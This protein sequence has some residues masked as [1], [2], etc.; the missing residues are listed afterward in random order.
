MVEE[1]P[2]AGVHV[3]GF[4]VIDRN[5]ISVELGHPVRRAWVEGGGFALGYRL[6]QAVELGGGGLVNTGA[7]GHP[8]EAN[9]FQQT[10]GPDTVRVGGVFR[11]IKADLDVAHR[12]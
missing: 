7:V 6:H 8:Q 2:V 10:Q 11:H 9:R 1:D 4:A 3:V 12:R 5:P